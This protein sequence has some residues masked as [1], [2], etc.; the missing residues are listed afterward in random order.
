MMFSGTEDAELILL[1]SR[2]NIDLSE[3]EQ[4]TT[5][6]NIDDLLNGKVDA[7][8]GYLTNEPYYLQQHGEQ[9]R[10]FKPSDYSINFYSDVI[11][12]HQDLADSQPKLVERFT[13]ASIKGW[14][15][16]LS[17]IEETLGVIEQQYQTQKT[18][19]HL[20]FELETAARMIMPEL[21][22]LGHMNPARWQSIAD[23]LAQLNIIPD[24][25]IDDGFLYPLRTELT[26][27]DFK[28]WVQIGAILL[29]VTS[30]ATGYFSY[31]NRQLK[32]EVT[33]RLEAEQ[34]AEEMARK[35]TLTGIANR[36]ALV[37]ELHRAVS[38]ITPSKASPAILFIDLDNFKAVN[39]TYGHQ[40][41]DRV[42]QQF[43]FRVD[44]LLNDE[45]SFF[46]R[47]AGDE[48]VILLSNTAES[49][50]KNLAEQISVVADKLFI[51]G[52]HK[53]QIGAS[54]GITFYRQGETHDYFLSRADNK[55]YRNKKRSRKERLE[56]IA[57]IPGH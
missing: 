26:W 2:H 3:L 31:V 9:A 36:Y 13:G 14:Y 33:R 46:A 56:S 57:R 25:T 53:I 48:F 55:M 17:H 50:A 10:I 42:L 43:C 6:A 30:L 20:A 47:L 7:F 34:R 44:A 52:Q 45:R 38:R 24:T 54:V 21:I 29:A 28:L 51:V 1:L 23:E 8:N 22:E 41:G 27:Q 5:S 35:D 11:F 12:T 18:R 19:A 40:A 32:L 4:V 49:E 37:E 15:Y 16:A 39:D